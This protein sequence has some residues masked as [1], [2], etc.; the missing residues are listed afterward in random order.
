MD[1][2]TI[3]RPGAQVLIKCEIRGVEINNHGDISYRVM[4]VSGN[5]LMNSVMV[6]SKDIKKIIK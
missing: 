2:T 6:S 5:H 4:P 1:T 3:I